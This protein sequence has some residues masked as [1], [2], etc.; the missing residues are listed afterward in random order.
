M[1]VVDSLFCSFGC[2]VVF[3]DFDFLNEILGLVSSSFDWRRACREISC[4]SVSVEFETMKGPS[5][6]MNYCV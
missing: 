4:R 2:L 3:V 5:A 6:L 1:R